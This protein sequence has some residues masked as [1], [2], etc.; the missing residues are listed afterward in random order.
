MKRKLLL[1]CVGG[2]LAVS[3]QPALAVTSSG[4]VQ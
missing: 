1:I 3:A 4:T 2:M